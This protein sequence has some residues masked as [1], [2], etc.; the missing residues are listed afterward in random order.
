MLE[1]WAFELLKGIGKIFLHPLLYWTF[2]L[3]C[4][5]GY[6][7]IKKERYNF[8]TKI[9]HYFTEIKYTFPLTVIAS[10]VLSAATILFGIVLSYEVMIVLAI[11]TIVFS[12]FGS[13]Q[14]LSASYTIGMTFIL[15]LV[16]PFLQRY[17]DVPYV[18]FTTISMVHFVGLTL[19]LAL[20]LLFEAIFMTRTKSKP[21]FPSLD[22]SERGVWVGKFEAKR[23]MMVPF[24]IL[25]PSDSVTAI[26]PFFPYFSFG[27]Q[28]F[29]LILLPF[30]LGY[31]Y[32]MQSGLPDELLGKIT[33][34]TYVLVVIVIAG[35]ITSIFYPFVS[36]ITIL[37]ALVGKEWMTYRHKVRDRESSPMFHPLDKGI[38]VF[39][40]MPNSPVERLGIKVGEI[41]LKV[42]NV[43]VTNSSEFYEALQ[44]SKTNFKID[45]LDENGE[46]RFVHGTFFAEDHYE[47]GL[48]F[49]EQPHKYKENE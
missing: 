4:I 18:D 11:V 16:L 19:L 10:I 24:F 40:M 33:K 41:I 23:M 37:V 31:Q 28:T 14:F 13:L 44:T 27:D 26:T 3:L 43:N 47:L 6:K 9:Y 1:Q 25:I 49:I 20:L 21:A 48:L 2:F 12:L 5:I 30:I 42:N 36:F 17:T 46:I 38:K 35:A 29:S 22:L 7:R 34:R 8:G 45:V 39:A 32:H 15:L